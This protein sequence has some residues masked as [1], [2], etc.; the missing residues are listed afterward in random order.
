MGSVK[1]LFCGNKGSKRWSAY[2][3]EDVIIG[4]QSIADLCV[5]TTQFHSSMRFVLYM[6]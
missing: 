2:V 1:S 5:C 4:P 3:L 6:V